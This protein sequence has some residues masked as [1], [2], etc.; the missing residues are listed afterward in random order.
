[1][2]EYSFGEAVLRLMAHVDE[3]VAEGIV[4]EE[5]CSRER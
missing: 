3:R 5:P 4:G 2:G 1:M